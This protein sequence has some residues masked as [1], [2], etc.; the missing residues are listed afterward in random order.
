MSQPA[1]ERCDS[2][3]KL[4][5][6]IE[7]RDSVVQH[8]LALEETRRRVSRGRQFDVAPE[9]RQPEPEPELEPAVAAWHNCVAAVGAEKG[10]SWGQQHRVL[11]RLYSDALGQPA[12]DPTP[13]MLDAGARETFPLRPVSVSQWRFLCAALSLKYQLPEP[14][15]IEAYLHVVCGG[16]QHPAWD[17]VKR[18]LH[19]SIGEPVPT[20]LVDSMSVSKQ[21]VPIKEDGLGAKLADPNAGSKHPLPAKENDD[22]GVRILLRRWRSPTAAAATISCYRGTLGSGNQTRPEQ[23]PCSGAGDV[24]TRGAMPMDAL[25]AGLRQENELLRSRAR[26]KLEEDAS[27]LTAAQAATRESLARRKDAARWLESSLQRMDHRCLVGKTAVRPSVAQLVAEREALADLRLRLLRQCAATPSP[28]LKAELARVDGLWKQHRHERALELVDDA[29][30]SLAQE[31]INMTLDR[32]AEADSAL[33]SFG[34]TLDATVPNGV[35]STRASIADTRRRAEQLSTLQHEEARG[36]AAR[37][38][39]RHRAN[40]GLAEARKH[41]DI[42]VRAVRLADDLKRSPEREA[43][44]RVF[45]LVKTGGR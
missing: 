42:A 7:V 13:I 2:L 26:L 5:A 29:Q 8:Q 33:E 6:R 35:R 31:K 25:I 27:R 45:P 32:L 44:E 20:N 39:S 30:R 43:V 28:A 3:R 4:S 16:S 41:Y 24:C 21:T 36:D 14:E 37:S 9:P 34:A 22:L 38:S 40:S 15:Q 11:A 19:S 1:A 10:G 12:R 18:Q 23:S 17:D